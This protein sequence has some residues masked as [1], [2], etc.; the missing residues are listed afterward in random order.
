MRNQQILFFPCSGFSKLTC[1]LFGG[2]GS[3]IKSHPGLCGLLCVRDSSLSHY[4]ILSI[5][6]VS[7]V[8]N[9]MFK[10]MTAMMIMFIMLAHMCMLLY[11]M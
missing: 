7:N 5:V 1:G 3:R 9:G 8:L 6:F 2:C 11:S 10:M 4:V